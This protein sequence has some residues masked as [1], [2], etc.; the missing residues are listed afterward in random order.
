MIAVIEQYQQEDGT[1]KVPEVLQPYMNGLK[2]IDGS[3][4][5]LHI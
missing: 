3:L 1:V 2:A 5:K 4:N